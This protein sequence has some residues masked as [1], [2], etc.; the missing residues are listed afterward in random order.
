V[1]LQNLRNRQRKKPKISE[2]KGKGKGKDKETPKAE[3]QRDRGEVDIIVH[4]GHRF[5]LEFLITENA[6]AKPSSATVINDILE[7]LQRFSKQDKYRD[8]VGYPSAVVNVTHHDPPPVVTIPEG[9]TV[10]QLYHFVVDNGFK[11]PK[12]IWDDKNG[13]HCVN[14]TPGV[15]ITYDP[16]TKQQRQLPFGDLAYL[17]DKVSM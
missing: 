11:N 8:V 3:R 5:F 15:P 10:A 2:E 14:F 7:H 12:L 1:Q 16:E 6:P 4:N 17:E 9:H 13:K